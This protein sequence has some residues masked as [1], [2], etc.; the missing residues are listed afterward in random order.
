MK[1]VVFGASGTIGGPL[2]AELAGTNEVVAVSRR[3][4]AAT[5]GVIWK[6]AD[7]TQRESVTHVLEGCEVVYYLVIPSEAPTSR[8]WISEPQRRP[9]WRRRAPV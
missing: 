3:E 1:V 6:T 2:L 5:P 7:A 9:R 8:S 4:Q